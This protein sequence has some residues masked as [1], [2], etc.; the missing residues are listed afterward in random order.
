[1]VCDDVAV[2]VKKASLQS[3]GLCRLGHEYCNSVFKKS[4]L[5]TSLHKNEKGKQLPIPIKD[6]I[7]HATSLLRDSAKP[8]FLGWS[9]S[10]QEAI[11][12]GLQLAQNQNGVFDSTASFEYG[13]MLGAKLKGGESDQV[14]LDDV[15]DFA[16]H[17]VYW[18]V[19]PAESH[20]RHASRFTVFP[21]GKNIPEGR[22]S[23]IVSV[24]D[25]RKTE[26][27]G[28]ANH[29]LI[30]SPITGDVEFL[31]T[32][33]AELKGTK[34]PLA[35]KVG[36]VPTIEFLSFAKQLREAETI[37]LFYGNGLIHST[38]SSQSLLLLKQLEKTLNRGKRHCW[39][40]PM[41]AYCNTIGS[42]KVSLDS[43]N[44]PFSI[45][46]SSNPPQS[47]ASISKSLTKGEF[48]S[49]MVTNWDALSLLPKPMAQA[50]STLPLI[51]FSTH[52][53]L[54]TKKSTIV[55]PTALTGAETQGTTYRMD[56]AAVLLKPFKEP[57]KGVLTEEELLKQLL[58]ALR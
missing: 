39:T 16:D 18:G 9:N 7:Q 17:I 38:H 56:G 11:Q 46:F 23:R 29:Q 40:L 35:E 48:D 4:R 21:K 43:S 28:L 55:F 19:N 2:A 47:V 14:S 53:T 33:I 22:E 8:L 12:T 57:P 36:G 52:P 44:L 51:S 45:D 31:Q 25:V 24:L 49:V 10:T 27:M 15:R 20:H 3:L 6:A 34:Q 58:T 54:T 1:M 41:V 37:A 13:Q 50:I 32:L 30:L 26:S 42:V 5:A